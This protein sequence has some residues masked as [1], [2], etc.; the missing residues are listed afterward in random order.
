MLRRVAVGYA[1]LMALL[2]AAVFVAPSWS[3]LTWAAIGLLGAGAVVF[4]AWW[5]APLRRAPWWF[6]AGAIIAMAAGD[7]IY[8]ATVHSPTDELPVVGDVCY[9]AMF[10]LVT[11]GLIQMTRTSVVLRD[12]ARLLAIL[13]FTCAAAL[14]TWVFVAGPSL[15]AESLD[16]L[17]KSTMSAY[18][19]G[20]LLVL[21]TTVR[22]LVAARRSVAVA[23]LVIG[24]GGGLV[25]DVAYTQAQLSSGWQTGGGWEIGYLLMY[26]CWGASALHPSMAELTLPVDARSTILRRRSMSLLVLSAAVPPTILIVDS[27]LGRDDN[28][29]VIGVVGLLI[30][31]FV[32]TRLADAITRH[33]QAVARERSLRK[34]CGDLV[35]ATEPTTVDATVRAAVATLMSPGVPH[36]LVFAVADSQHVYFPLPAASGARRT[37]LLSTRTLHPTLRDELE[38]HP[39]T[40]VCPLVRDHRGDGDPGIGTLFV[41]ADER[42]L[43]AMRDAVEVLAAQATLAL[44]RIALT[45]AVARR[46]SDEYMRAVVQNTTDVVLIVDDDDRIRYASPSLSA[47]LGTA[48]PPFA[49]LPDIIDAEDYPQVAHSLTLAQDAADQNGVPDRWSLLRVDGSRV[50]VEVNCRDLRQDR[51]VRGFVITMRDITEQHPDEQELIQRALWASPGGKNRRS[52]ADKFR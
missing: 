52:S 46:D 29:I 41:A 7:T 27:L 21:I 34:A 35:A 30:S 50:L 51:M 3:A 2:S 33:Q 49:T 32:I 28:K 38:P 42:V 13:T 10:P 19:L 5:H 6:L 24:A 31:A 14:V 25:S 15:R 12:R 39:A 44:E 17:D 22:L 45:E 8:G 16:N 26:V 40:L 4:G 9:L 18:T 48:P 20:D 23:L 43:A 47:V 11:A 36:G 37:R 1:A